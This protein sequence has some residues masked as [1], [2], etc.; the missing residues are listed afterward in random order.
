MPAAIAV[1]FSDMNS[2]LIHPIVFL[3]LCN[4][5]ILSDFLKIF[6]EEIIA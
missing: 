6:Q 3:P 5:L 1:I 4:F 2:L